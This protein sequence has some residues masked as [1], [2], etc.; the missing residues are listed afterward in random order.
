MHT[1][2]SPIVPDSLINEEDGHPV[3][4][5]LLTAADLA[6]IVEDAERERQKQEALDQAATVPRG[7]LYA[8]QEGSLLSEREAKLGAPDK[9]T[10]DSS[11]LNAFKQNGIVKAGTLPTVSNGMLGRFAGQAVSGDTESSTVRPPG[12]RTA[13]NAEDNDM[14]DGDAE[15]GSGPATSRKASHADSTTGKVDGGRKDKQRAAVTADVQMEDV[16]SEDGTLKA[17][18][19]KAKKAKQR[20]MATDAAQAEVTGRAQ[21]N[22]TSSHASPSTG[23]GEVKPKKLKKKLEA[24]TPTAGPSSIRNARSPLGA[25]STDAERDQPSRINGSAANPP[26]AGKKSRPRIES[27]DDMAVDSDD[28]GDDASYREPAPVAMNG[29]GT[30][31]GVKRKEGRASEG[32]RATGADVEETKPTTK[33]R[34][35]NGNADQPDGKSQATAEPGR[36]GVKRERRNSGGSGVTPSEISGRNHDERRSGSQAPTHGKLVIP[37][38]ADRD[39]FK[40]VGN[41]LLP[42]SDNGFQCW[43]GHKKDV[44]RISWINVTG[45]STDRFKHNIAFVQG[46]LESAELRFSGQLR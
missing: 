45:T 12:R 5:A 20:E 32:N 25:A 29:R 38:D 21:V 44:S 19:P 18:K 37:K 15:V 39:L 26:I 33:K 17:T 14:E 28:G 36:N 22:G 23:A 31:K 9:Q 8:P 10:V 16:E 43:A 6:A 1:G 42:G 7:D 40:N 34:K 2:H 24:E 4:S 30:T 27:D 46:G 35:L 41:P 13:A 3:N 11:L